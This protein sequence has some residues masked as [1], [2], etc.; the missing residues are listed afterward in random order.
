MIGLGFEDF[1]LMEAME[2]WSAKLARTVKKLPPD[3]VPATPREPAQT[4]K[5]V[6]VWPDGT[7]ISHP[8]TYSTRREHRMDISTH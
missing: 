2:L 3:H 8:S 4:S 6:F 1:E 7:R 5:N